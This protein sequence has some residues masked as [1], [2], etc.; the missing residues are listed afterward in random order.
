M[1]TCMFESFPFWV[2]LLDRQNDINAHNH[3]TT[4]Q[5]QTAHG[6]DPR[7]VLRPPLQRVHPLLLARGRRPRV[8]GCVMLCM[9]VSGWVCRR[10]YAVVRINQCTYV[11]DRRMRATEP[12]THTIHTNG[13]HRLD[14]TGRRLAGVPGQGRGQPHLP[15]RRLHQG[16]QSVSRAGGRGGG[17]CSM[18]IYP[19]PHSTTPTPTPNRTPSTTCGP[20]TWTFPRASATRSSRPRP[21]PRTR[22]GWH[23]SL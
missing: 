13:T 10:G 16:S 14:P 12:T 5:H 18:S 3:H 21:P 7:A 19:N 6:R 15:P 8:G 9:W 2:G 11:Q 23:G 22:Y 17:R 20:S 1:C 4:T